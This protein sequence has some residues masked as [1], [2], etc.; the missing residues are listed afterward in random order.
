MPEGWDPANVDW[1]SPPSAHVDPPKPHGGEAKSPVP[2][3]EQLFSI[4]KALV[5]AVNALHEVEGLL[6]KES[7]HAGAQAI[8]NVES[9]Y[10]SINSYLRNFSGRGVQSF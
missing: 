6:K 3:V 8:A 2:G 9:A 1:F 7:P 10:R 4:Q 5:T